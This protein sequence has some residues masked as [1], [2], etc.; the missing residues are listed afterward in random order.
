V[1]DPVEL[2]LAASYLARLPEGLDSYPSCRIRTEVTELVLQRFPRILD[3]PGLSPAFADRLKRALEQDE[4]MSETLGIVVRM[5][6]RDS[7]FQSDAEYDAWTFEISKELY[8]RRVYRVL[9]YLISPS[10]V[11]LGATRRWN[12][13]R[14][15]TNLV[16][17]S[18]S[19]GGDL[20]LEFPAH[21]YPP[22]VLGGLGQ[23]FRAALE[24]ARARNPRVEL[25]QVEVDRARWSVTWD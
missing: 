15:G 4:W 17:K 8:T 1:F 14:Q 12:A 24:A 11:V 5:V 7:V 3:H 22:L 6:A 19:N 13:F 25:D 20:E 2:P 18:H 21:L 10:L 9:M 16:A 23:A